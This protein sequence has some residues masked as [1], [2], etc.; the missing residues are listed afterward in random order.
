MLGGNP[1]PFGP[2]SLTCAEWQAVFD[3]AAALEDD[4][5]LG[6]WTCGDHLHVG[7]A[8][9]PR[10]RRQ[11]QGVRPSSFDPACF[12]LRL[13]QT[14]PLN[15]RNFAAA[16]QQARERW[17]PFLAFLRERAREAHVGA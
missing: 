4:P 13:W 9:R 14:V 2:G 15:P 1:D 7:G 16:F 11:L 12:D 10:D 17:V 8:V 5:D 6:V 3:L